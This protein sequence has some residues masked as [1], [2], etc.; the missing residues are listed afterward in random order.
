[1][2]RIINNF[3]Q[4]AAKR[5]ALVWKHVAFVVVYGVGTVWAYQLAFGG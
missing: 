1:M 2:P 4:L 3:L 5:A